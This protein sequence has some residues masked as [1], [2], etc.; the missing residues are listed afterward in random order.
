MDHAS[1]DSPFDAVDPPVRTVAPSPDPDRGEADVHE[2][3]RHEL[4]LLQPVVRA[5]PDA[6][7]ALLHPD[8]AEIGASGRI[9]DGPGIARALAAESESR[10][11]DGDG[12]G[13]EGGTE[14]GT[15]DGDA[16]H[17]A[18][19][20]DL[21]Y[22]RLAQDVTLL[23]YTAHEPVRVSRRTSIWVREN[24]GTWLLRLHQGTTIAGRA[25]QH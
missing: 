25:P 18:R 13:T 24:G 19:I 8:F 21:E 22:L 4:R 9:W 20:E 15:G 10:D 6:V 5:D 7:L 1:A 17:I 16:C 3:L 14:G 11:G 12:D 2:V 23:T